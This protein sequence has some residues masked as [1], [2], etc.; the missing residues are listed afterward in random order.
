MLTCPP[1]LLEMS[2][3]RLREVFSSVMPKRIFT[4]EFQRQCEDDPKVFIDLLRKLNDAVAHR[5][6]VCAKPEAI[7]SAIL[8][9]IEL[10]HVI[11][12]SDM[13]RFEQSAG[14][15]MAVQREK[16]DIRHTM[17]LRSDMADQAVPLLKLFKE[18]TLIMD[19]VTPDCVTFLNIPID[20]C[21]CV[22]RCVA[23]SSQE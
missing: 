3:N 19:E 10:L 21:C 11:E 5:G 7:K 23:P 2:R 4:F 1:N 16:E 22:G 18:G 8:K 20:D 14:D 6:I 12:Q 15:N 13:G 9:M 17:G